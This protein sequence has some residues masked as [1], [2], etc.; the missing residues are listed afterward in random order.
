MLVKTNSVD[1]IF[2]LASM[3]ENVYILKTLRDGL[4]DRSQ[5]SSDAAKYGRDLM[6]PQKPEPVKCKIKSVP[7]RPQIDKNCQS[8]R[9]SRYLLLGAAVLGCIALLL[10]TVLLF[11]IDF[12]SKPFDQSGALGRA[13]II[14][15][16][17]ALIILSASFILKGMEMARFREE[18][19]SWE[20]IRLQ[21]NDQN[22]QEIVRCQNLE[23][24]HAVEYNKKL[25]EYERIKKVH[26]LRENVK[27]RIYELLKSKIHV[28]A[29]SGE[30]QLYELHS[31]LDAVPTEY[32]RFD[33]MQKIKEYI[34]N[35]VASTPEKAVS[36]YREDAISEKVPRF[37]S[38]ILDKNNLY[39]EMHHVYDRIAEISSAVNDSIN[40]LQ[41]FIDP[42]IEKAVSFED[43]TVNDTVLAIEFAK[44]FPGS[45][46]ALFANE[47]VDSCLAIYS[48][49]VK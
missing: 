45:S 3:E 27:A 28:L 42:I 10:F 4:K 32:R 8:L 17:L 23:G 43:K 47:I 20:A 9:R 40:A 7:E 48:K 13:L 18:M 21:I 24:L 25:E 30:K 29:V 34:Q 44:N 15:C 37:A 11:R 22:E 19:K 49:Y 12:F 33:S 41:S 46:V 5:K 38:D 14:I 35:G 1:N 39:T 2:D 26:T 31:A 36:Q 16:A 6:P